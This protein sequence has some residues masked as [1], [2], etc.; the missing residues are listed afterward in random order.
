MRNLEV[1]LVNLMN[2]EIWSFEILPSMWAREQ[3]IYSLP[4]TRREANRNVA[5]PAF[6]DTRGPAGE[7]IQHHRSCVKCSR[8]VWHPS[9]P[10]HSRYLLCHWGRV[11]TSGKRWA[12]GNRSLN[13]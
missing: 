2:C 13:E 4:Y 6:D 11:L 5:P 9:S 7:W 1:G 3:M 12:V 8:T 10:N